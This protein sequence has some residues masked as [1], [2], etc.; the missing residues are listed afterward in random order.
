MFNAIR[1]SLHNIHWRAH[2]VLNPIPQNERLQ[3]L[4]KRDATIYD[5]TLACNERTDGGGE[6]HQKPH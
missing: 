2:E 5:D 6:E 1:L 4:R 3:V